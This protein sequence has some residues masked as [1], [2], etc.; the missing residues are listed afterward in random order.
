MLVPI[1][2]ERVIVTIKTP[3]QDSKVMQIM[4]GR[5]DGSLYVNF[6]YFKYSR[7]LI[8]LAR[9]AGNTSYPANI[10]L[11]KGGKITSHL[12]KYAHHP[13]GRAHF[14]QDG[15]IRTVVRKQ[16]VPLAEAEGHL[17]TVQIQGL[18]GFQAVDERTDFLAS[19]KK[20]SVV[21]IELQDT[22]LNYETFKLVG[23][24]HSVNKFTEG[25][26]GNLVGPFVPTLKPDGQL[27]P[28]V[29]ISAPLNYPL[30]DRV[31]VI[32]TENIPKLTEE[33]D[34]VL[35][36]IGGF[37]P[38]SIMLDLSVDANFLALSYPASDYSEL[39]LRLGSVDLSG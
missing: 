28:G 11:T 33:E 4:Y 5:K 10:D 37:D 30:S 26:V 20:K 15:K 9:L 31:L 17:F 24:W 12:V 19:P 14:S 21:T 6:P 39:S 18:Q 25:I 8:S 2:S 22:P 38:P 35:T 36:F 3:E 32:T 23:R 7:G 16:S 34:T 13:D 29:L 1:R 27:I